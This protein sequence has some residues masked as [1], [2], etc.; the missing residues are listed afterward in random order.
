[1]VRGLDYYTRTTFEVTSEFL[2]AQNAVVGGGRY[3]HLVRDL[4]GPDISGIGF[5]I[6]FERLA[7]MIPEGDADAVVPGPFFSSRP[8][9]KRRW[10][11]PF[12]YATV[13]G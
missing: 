13:C 11:R 9:A 3:D 12:F 5:A 7:A 10:K 6:G 1:M 2:G 8:S 4:G